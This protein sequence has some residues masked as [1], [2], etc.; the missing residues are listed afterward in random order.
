MIGSNVL[1]AVLFYIFLGYVLVSISYDEIF[2][3]QAVPIYLISILA[4]T[5]VGS[6]SLVYYFKNNKA[7]RLKTFYVFISLSIMSYVLAEISWALLE[8]LHIN[9]YMNIPDIFYALYFIFGIR[10]CIS[11]FWCRIQLIPKYYKA[12]PAIIT[13]L[14]LLAYTILSID[15]YGTLTFWFG[16][17]MMLFSASLLGCSALATL[18]VRKAPKL[19]LIGSLFGIAF[20]ANSLGDIFYYAAENTGSYAITDWY[21]IVWAGTPLILIYAMIRHRFLY[22]EEDAGTTKQKKNKK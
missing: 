22:S 1:P 9:P 12:I 16:F 21:S 18:T 14:G 7:N 3:I 20:L 19:G 11:L 8:S 15:Q 17:M 10:A 6:L 5:A 4:I 2:L 13:L